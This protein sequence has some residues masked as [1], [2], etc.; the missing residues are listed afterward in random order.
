[1]P[2]SRRRTSKGQSDAKRKLRKPEVCLKSP[3]G[4]VAQAAVMGPSRVP[5]VPLG[6][7]LNRDRGREGV[8]PG[9]LQG[10]VQRAGAPA[11]PGGAG[12]GWGRGGVGAGVR[13]PG[14]PPAP[15]SRQ[16]RGSRH[17]LLT[18]PSLPPPWTLLD[19]LNGR[20][21]FLESS[22]CLGAPARVTALGRAFLCW[23]PALRDPSP[24]SAHTFWR[25]GWTGGCDECEA[26]GHV[27]VPC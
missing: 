27:C 15:A 6:G 17:I 8:S 16:R 26:L 7:C 2:A 4:T 5:R 14:E 9:C 24:R 21:S 22:S 23:L 13:G 3:S 11:R 20:L 1:M 10:A 19:R 12:A 25:G 18:S